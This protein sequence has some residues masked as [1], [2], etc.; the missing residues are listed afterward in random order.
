MTKKQ[1][2]EKLA[3]YPDDMDVFVASRKTEFTYGLVN[4]VRVEKIGMSEDPWDEPK[5][6]VDA[7]II[8]EE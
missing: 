4:S 8:D 2:I 6:Y 3:P 1:L 5:C 7:I